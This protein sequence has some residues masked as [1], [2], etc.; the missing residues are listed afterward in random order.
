MVD[1]G[2]DRQNLLRAHPPAPRH[3]VRPGLRLRRLTPVRCSQLELNTLVSSWIAI[4]GLSEFLI[5]PSLGTFSDA[6]SLPS[7]PPQSSADDSDGS[8]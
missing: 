1:S 8:A 5:N 7:T 6:V 4:I 2:T 3:T